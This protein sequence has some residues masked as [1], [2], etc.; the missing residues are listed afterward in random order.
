MGRCWIS[1]VEDVKPK[2][3]PNP[4]PQK[5]ADP[6]EAINPPAFTNWKKL[7]EKR[8]WRKEKLALALAL[9]CKKEPREVRNLTQKTALASG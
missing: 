4:R 5:K 8:P 9:L 2:A 7:A 3:K 1:A 6:L